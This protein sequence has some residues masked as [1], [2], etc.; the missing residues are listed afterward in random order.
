MSA[1]HEERK[2]KNG[3]NIQQ[4][5]ESYVYTTKDD[6]TDTAEQP[7]RSFGNVQA[8]TKWFAA[9]GLAED[10][11]AKFCDL[12]HDWWP[13][14]WDHPV[15]VHV[16]TPCHSSETAYRGFDNAFTVD[17]THTP[18]RMVYRHQALRDASYTTTHLGGSGLCRQQSIAMPIQEMNNMRFCT[19]MD[20]RARSD[21]HVPLSPDTTSDGT[22]T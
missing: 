14:S 15:G 5:L 6:T 21:I 17:R 4:L 2:R 10:G 19:R 3:L 1:I 16:T 12:I 22:D 8:D 7:H 11:S 20:M 18:P 9:E 13:E